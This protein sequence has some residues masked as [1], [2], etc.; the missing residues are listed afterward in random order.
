MSTGSTGVSRPPRPPSGSAT[1][2]RSCCALRQVHRRPGRHRPRADQPCPRAWMSLASR[3]GA[4][5]QPGDRA[6]RAEPTFVAR[7]R[8]RRERIDAAG[9]SRIMKGVLTMKPDRYP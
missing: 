6:R 8:W 9:V 3:R 2:L 5:A 1:A 7:S 4:P